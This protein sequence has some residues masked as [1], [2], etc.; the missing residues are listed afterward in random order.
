MTKGRTLHQVQFDQTASHMHHA[1]ELGIQLPANFD[2]AKYKSLSKSAR[3]AYA[4]QNLPAELIIRYQNAIGLAM[5]PTFGIPSMG[6]RGFAGARKSDIGLLYK[7]VPQ[8]P[9]VLL[10]SV[11]NDQGIHV[12]SY[13][14]T[15][16][17]FQ[18]MRKD[19]FWI[20]KDKPFN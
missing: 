17:Q 16:S 7:R 3:I 18:K 13:P 11:I 6:I 12:S 10:M 20:W 15:I 1:G 9:N 8:D 5:Q 14:V 4:K 19:D 2:L